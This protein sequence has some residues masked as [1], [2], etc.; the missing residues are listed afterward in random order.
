M[1]RGF[2]SITFL[3]SKTDDVSLVEAQ[4]SLDLTDKMEPDWEELKKLK[5]K[6]KS[7][8]EQ[9]NEIDKQLEI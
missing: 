4:D 2:N 8:K 3:C 6:T 1:N 5:K 7:M 9:I